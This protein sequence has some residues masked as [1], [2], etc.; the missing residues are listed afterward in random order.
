MRHDARARRAPSATA[1]TAQYLS[2][3]LCV[4][5]SGG[6]TLALIA[7]DEAG[8]ADG[9]TGGAGERQTLRT[10]LIDA[11]D[12]RRRPRHAHARTCAAVRLSRSAHS[13]R[14]DR[15]APRRHRADGAARTS[16]RPTTRKRCG[17]ELAAVARAFAEPL[18]RDR[19][20]LLADDAATAALPSLACKYARRE[21]PPW[22]PR[23]SGGAGGGAAPSAARRG[24][25]APTR[26]R[27]SSGSRRRAREA[28]QAAQRSQRAA[29]GRRPARRAAARR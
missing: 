4:A 27:A 13:R 6:G 11:R 7:R 22:R 18:A 1:R 26:S 21:P 2:Q 3:A 15:G 12:G 25:R 23:P 10:V 29:R 9:S 28:P 20:L 17:A 8:R 14:A 24:G 16:S 5:S 19:A